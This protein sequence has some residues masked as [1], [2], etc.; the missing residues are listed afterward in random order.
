MSNRSVLSVLAENEA[1]K[2]EVN[3]LRRALLNLSKELVKFLEN[4]ERK[5]GSK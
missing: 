3:A 1:L 5:G 4:Q 2:E